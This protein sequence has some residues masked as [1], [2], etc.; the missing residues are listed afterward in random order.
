MRESKLKIK[1]KESNKWRG[2]IASWYS[3]EAWVPKNV[4][5]NGIPLMVQPRE[6]LQ[7]TRKITTTTK[8]PL[9]R[10]NSKPIEEIYSTDTQENNKY[11]NENK[12]KKKGKSKTQKQQHQQR[13]QRRRLGRALGGVWGTRADKAYQGDVGEHQKQPKIV[14]MGRGMPHMLLRA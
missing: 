1:E 13:R 11:K 9:M 14:W 10:N 7:H 8:K 5:C 4:V 6:L 2:L 12:K 3:H